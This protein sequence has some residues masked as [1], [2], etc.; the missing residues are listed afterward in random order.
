DEKVKVLRMV[1]PIKLEDVV[2]GQYEAA[3]VNGEKKP[4][5]KDDDSI[6]NKDTKT[7]TYAAFAV[8][9]DSERWDGVPFILKAGKALDE[10]KV[11]KRLQ[12][13]PVTGAASHQIA[14]NE[15]VFR[16]QPTEAIYLKMNTKFPGLKSE[17]VVTD[18]D[19]SYRRRFSNVQIPQAYESLILDCLNGD[20]S[21]F[22]RDDELD[23]AWQIITPLLESINQ[24]KLKIEK[25]PYGSR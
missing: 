18:L 1:R 11:E 25:Y 19:L 20:H 6:K 7:P 22:V 23:E 9:I 13:K 24:D 17:A 8:Y 5:Y 10:T 3:E 16:G 2:L 15:L 21:N 4:G 14:R 12:F